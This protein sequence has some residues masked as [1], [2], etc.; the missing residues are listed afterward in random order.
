MACIDSNVVSVITNNISI[1]FKQHLLLMGIL[2]ICGY[3]S[4]PCDTPIVI[5]LRVL[6]VYFIFTLCFLF[7]KYILMTLYLTR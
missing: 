4:N 7:Y 3:R 5:S 2:N 6:V 1:A